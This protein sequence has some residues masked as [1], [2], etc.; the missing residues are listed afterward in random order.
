MSK[1]T[2]IK[3]ESFGSQAEFN[4]A[5]DR[6]TWI[7]TETRRL[8]ALRDAVLLRVKERYNAKIETLVTERELT[9]T[10]CALYAEAN[11]KTLLPDETKAKSRLTR[12]STWGFRLGQQKLETLKGWTWQKVL[13]ALK[14]KGLADYIR[15]KEEVDKEG[16]IAD[17]KKHGHLCIHDETG[18]A[19]LP[20][21]LPEVGVRLVQEEAFFIEPKVEEAKA[22]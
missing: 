10:R 9:V 5:V 20:V 16:I 1:T 7:D 3:A 13:G 18:G 22:S 21:P 8:E 14:A 19:D 4:D 2:R 15:T 17:A 12:L 6:V 11:R